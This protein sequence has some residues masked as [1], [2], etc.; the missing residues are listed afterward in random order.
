MG[1]YNKT[2]T[3]AKGSLTLEAA[4]VV[5]MFIYAIIAFIYFLQ[6]INI[7]EAIQHAISETGL[8]TVRYAYVYEYLRDFN[9]KEAKDTED[10]NK[11]ISQ[12]FN[13][14]ESLPNKQESLEKQE[15]PEKQKFSKTQ[16]IKNAAKES[17]D[18]KV[19]EKKTSAEAMIAKFIDSIY[20]KTKMRDH[21]E[22]DFIENSCIKGGMGGISTYLSAFMEEDDMIDIIVTYRVKLPL[23]FLKLEE[24]QLLQRVR[25]RGWTGYTPKLEDS[26]DYSEEDTDEDVVYIT[27][28]GTVYHVSKNCSHLKLS[29]HK[30]LLEEL[31]EL[32]NDSGGKYQ[33][34]HLCKSDTK[35]SQAYV[36]ITDTG[37][38]YHLKLDCSG[39]K[40]TVTSIP[41]S[42]VGSRTKCKR[43]KKESR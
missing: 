23:P 35:N 20:F 18:T 31:K 43:C 27:E 1:R 13:K 22:V 12:L 2:R 42:E 4:L 6:I 21:L 41:I 34:C 40:R 15:L 36:Y 24:L 11:Q 29:T 32:R 10:T 7:Q 30:A 33:E 26:K 5:P 19:E 39:L 38:R 28:T 17:P 25:M 9:N 37:D 3:K 14:Q 8:E 16:E